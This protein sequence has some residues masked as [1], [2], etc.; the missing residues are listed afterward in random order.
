MPSPRH[1]AYAV[2][3]A[4]FVLGCSESNFEPVAPRAL[5]PPDVYRTWW[6]EVE[7]CIGTRAPFERIRWYQA[8]QL[9]NK[10]EGT[11]HAGA[12]LPPHTIYIRSDRLLFTVAVKHEM[13]HELLQRR[14]HETL[15]F[16][17]CAG[18]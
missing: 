6:D 18:L 8:E 5:D 10:E 4:A 16:E 13:V 12:W 11:G 15:F 3:I 9:V 2:L 17:A 14:D 1:T 7:T